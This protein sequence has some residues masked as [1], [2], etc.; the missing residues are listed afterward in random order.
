MR[1]PVQ[2]ALCSERGEGAFTVLVGAQVSPAGSYRPPESRYEAPYL[3]QTIIEVPVQT[4]L[5]PERASGAFV[6]LVGDQVSVAGS[7]R[8]PELNVE[9]PPQTIIWLP[10][11]TTLWESRGSGAS[12]RAPLSHLSSSRQ[13]EA[14]NISRPCLSGIGR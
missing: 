6:V 7:Y 14:E 10:V 5:C 2:M 12:S 1:L 9:L 3:P 11:Q 4:A 13:L 8:P